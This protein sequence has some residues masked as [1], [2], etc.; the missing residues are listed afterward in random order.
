LLILLNSFNV[1]PINQPYEFSLAN[2]RIAYADP[3][4][5]HSILNTLLV[6]A[7]YTSISFPTAIFIAWA[8]ARTNIWFSHRLEFLFWLSFMLPNTATT[9]GWIYLLDPRLGIINRAL[10][11][12]PFIDKGPGPFNIFSLPG[13]VWAH[14]MANAVS[15]KVML[16]TPAFRNM[17]AALEEAATVSGADKIRTT[18]K[19]T[20][21]VMLPALVI[22]FFMN[23]IRMLQSFETEQLLGAPIGF[24]VYSTQIYRD[25]RI[26]FPPA[27]GQ[28]TALGSLALVVVAAVVPLQGWLLRRRHYTTVTGQFR[29]GRTDLGMWRPIVFVGIF[30][31]AMLLTLMPT[32][33]LLGGSFM[34]R[35][36]NFA[37]QPTFSLRHWEEV[38]SSSL[39]ID[40][41]KTTFVLSA[42]TAI[43]S[44]LIFSIVA[45]ILV[46]TQWPGRLL[47][48]WIIWMSSAIPGILT[49]LGLLWLLFAVPFLIPLYGTI[50]VLLIVV[51]LQGNLVTTQ[52][53]KAGILQIGRDMEDQAR[54]S[55][56]GWMYT[57]V[58]IWLPLLMPTL[59]MLGVLNFVFAAGTTSSIILLAS[60]DTFTL[61]IMVLEM[62]R[63][64][65]AAEI[66]QAGIVSLFMIT[67]TTGAAL[68]ARYLGR[69]SGVGGSI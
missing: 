43:L 20:L 12:L 60:H 22:V 46:R 6:Y 29:P 49:G 59:I 47:L 48:E 25:L 19:V 31:F 35:L 10:E 1:A 53:S 16:L 24:Y 7:L 11:V 64:P 3:S 55:G 13:I 36:G 32:A 42:T 27:Y 15:G 44:P 28:A 18:L 51:V 8:L 37:A 45:Y 23:L 52:M 4:I 62:M 56:A 5:F 58:R 30:G 34:N 68:V 69:R 14:L 41:V 67:M 65:N 61:S 66:E 63:A 57:Y 50:Y 40:A 2:W 38:L 26:V 21:P 33:T 54:V 17:D 9:M 39:I